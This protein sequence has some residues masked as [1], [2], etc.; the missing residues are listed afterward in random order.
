MGRLHA[1][2]TKGAPARDGGGWHHLSLNA[3][4]RTADVAA[5]LPLLDELATTV[6]GEQRDGVKA[7]R[8]ALV[9]LDLCKGLPQALVHVDFA[10]PNLLKASDGMITVID[11]TGSGRGS[12]IEALASLLAPWQKTGLE[13]GVAA[14]RKHVTPTDK[15]LAAL[16]G[17]LLTHQLVLAAWGAL[18]RPENIVPVAKRLPDAHK[19]FA[20]QAKQI[21]KLF[22]ACHSENG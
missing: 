14:Y 4:G 10:G 9:G 7:I 15:E 21:T 19:A 13:E 3:G 2:P 11:W 16:P 1:L 18:F 22:A 17:T 12:R 8:D 20:A 6:K 5:L